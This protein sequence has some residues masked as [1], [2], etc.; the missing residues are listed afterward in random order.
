MT[1]YE[2]IIKQAKLFHYKGWEEEELRMCVDML[3][4]LSR[5]EE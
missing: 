3:P 2:Y 4:S 5:H 1:D